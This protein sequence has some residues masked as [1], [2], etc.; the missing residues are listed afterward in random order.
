M[1]Y[2]Y[3]LTQL[4]QPPCEAGNVIFHFTEEETEA[5]E[6]EPPAQAHAELAFETEL[7]ASLRLA[8]RLRNRHWCCYL[9]FPSLRFLSL[10]LSSTICEMGKR[11]T[12]RWS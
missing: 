6:S 8:L 11:K 12:E 7:P 9:R 2:M 4:S 10:G 5:W 3:N 1:L